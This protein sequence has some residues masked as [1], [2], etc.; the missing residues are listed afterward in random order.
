LIDCLVALSG[1]FDSAIVAYLAKN[2]LGEDRVIAA[3]C[4]NNHIFR[5][6][7]KNAIDIASKIKYQVDTLYMNAETNDLLMTNQSNR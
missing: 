1:G 5:Y 2:Y 6:Q 4:V 3:T 7:I